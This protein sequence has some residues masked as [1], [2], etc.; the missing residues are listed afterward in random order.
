MTNPIPNPTNDNES[1]KTRIYVTGVAIGAMLGFLSA[2]LFA[3]EIE[4]DADLDGPDIAPTTL[5]GL[6]LS[7]LALV[8]QI[9]ESGKKKKK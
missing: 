6:A 4:N 9:A 2:Y 3:R 1:W 8:R 7:T 5:L